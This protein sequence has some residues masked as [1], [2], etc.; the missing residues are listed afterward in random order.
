M[1]I[2]PQKT[3]YLIAICD[4]KTNAI[5]KADIWSSPEYRQSRCLPQRTYVAYEITADT[6]QQARD[7]LEEV[8]KDQNSRY[9]YL[10]QYLPKAP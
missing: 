7:Y 4:P 8:I 9:H 5:I 6:Y 1:P 3:A 2:Q 10:Y